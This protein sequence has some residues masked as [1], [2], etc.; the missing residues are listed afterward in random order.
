MNSLDASTENLLTRYRLSLEAANR[1]PKTIS[2]YFPILHRFFGFLK[3]KGKS[4]KV[5]EIGREEVRAYIKY[6]QE[7]ERWANKPKN[8]KDRGN[9][10][11][12]SIQ[13]HVRAIKAF[14]GWLADDGII[15][16]NPLANFPLP[17]V[18][19]YVIKILTP[20]QIKLLLSSIDKTTSLGFKYYCIILLF[21][22]TGMRI[23][24]LVNIK[25]NDIDS[26]HGF[27][28]VLG[29]GRKQ[30][31]IPLLRFTIRELQRYQ[32]RFRQGDGFADSPYLFPDKYGGSITVNS[33][34]QYLR[35]L[36]QKAA[37]DVKVTP[38]VFRHTFGTNA[39]VRGVNAFILKEMMGH[40]S[41]QTT[42]RYTHPQPDDLKAQ[43]NMFSMVNELFNKK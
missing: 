16:S 31:I 12:Y 42:S 21:V 15:E 43:H 8:G 38:H 5:N 17:K 18:P 1:S 40:S 23:S 22:D 4:T 19:Q 2:W 37:L 14:F 3:D 25:V 13:G 6:L 36:A 34:Q 9:M 20:E 26:Q 11:A 29:K 27:V 35:R 28:T 41:I 33:V 24:E 30:R 32:N 39:A 7:A 10:S